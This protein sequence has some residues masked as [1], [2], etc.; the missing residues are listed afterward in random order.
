MKVSSFVSLH[1]TFN[2]I[3]LYVTMTLGRSIQSEETS[4]NSEFD[5]NKQLDVTTYHIGKTDKEKIHKMATIVDALEK[6]GVL[7]T[8]QKNC[9]TVEKIVKSLQT[10]GDATYRVGIYLYIK[11]VNNNNNKDSSTSLQGDSLSKQSSSNSS[12]ELSSNSSLSSSSSDSDEGNCENLTGTPINSDGGSVK[13]GTGKISSSNSRTGDDASK[14]KHPDKHSN[15]I[16]VSLLNFILQV[17]FV[18]ERSTGKAS[19]LRRSCRGN[20]KKGP[21]LIFLHLFVSKTFELREFKF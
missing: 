21:N 2:F 7:D 6:L 19:R 18:L 14:T 15:H 4:K 20:T 13:T 1:V 8:S 12:S 9:Y 17:L 5:N 3:S 10:E 16:S 11:E